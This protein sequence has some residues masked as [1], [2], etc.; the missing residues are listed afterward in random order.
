MDMQFYI[1]KLKSSKEFQEFKKEN[2]E[3]YFCSGFF[4]TDKQKNNTEVHLD[5]YIPLKNKIFSFKLGEKIEKNPVEMFDK[6]IPE[7]I[8]ENTNANLE[9]IE[10]IIKEK[11]QEE[12]INKKIQKILLSLQNLDSKTY[13]IG[14]IFTSN[15]GIV[16]IKINL[17]EKEII[18]FE[19]KSFLDMVNVLRKGK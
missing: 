5:Y 19:K 9:E 14:T 2:K 13:L 16:K 7:K 4:S 11:F 18:E 3:A 12:K 10:K 6:R 1:E 8:P 15:L 17:P